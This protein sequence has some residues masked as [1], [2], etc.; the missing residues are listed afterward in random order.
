MNRNRRLA[1]SAAALIALAVTAPLA[2][3]GTALAAEPAG[4]RAEVSASVRLELPAPTGKFAVGRKELHLVDRARTDPWLPTA[5][6][7]ELMVS[8]HYPAARK[9]TRATS[10]YMTQGE[11]QLLLEGMRRAEEFPAGLLAGTRTNSRPD[12]RPLP[13]KH[14]LVLLSPGY[15]L[16]RATLTLLAEELAS[17]GYVVAAMDHAYESFGT[18]FPGGRTLELVK[19]SAAQVVSVRAADASFVLDRL[20]DRRSPF[21]HLVDRRRIGMAGHSIGGNG[22]AAAMA[23]D[24]RIGAG[25]NLDGAFF[26]TP[27]GA[28]LKGRP[29]LLLGTDATHRPGGKGKWGEAWSAMDGWKRWLT[30]AGTGH[31]SFNDVPVLGGQ[32][33]VVD[34]T[35]PLPGKRSGEITR[36]YVA[37]FFDRHLKGRPTPLLDGPTAANP[38]VTFHNP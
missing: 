10:P 38:E 4:P 15:G 35:A 31:F 16:H 23:A 14:P 22:A 30:V 12:A 17:R 32:I 1:A 11:A 20:L 29:F 26:D 25:A 6:P 27:P 13:G 8:V 7:R 5:G 37:A 19:A 9:G 34:P 24:P 36:D 3:A 18:R 21:A 2:G 28:G 33:G